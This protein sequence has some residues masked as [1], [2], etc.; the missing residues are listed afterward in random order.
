MGEGF[1]RNIIVKENE[2]SM[3]G[4]ALINPATAYAGDASKSGG[5]DLL[6]FMTLFDASDS[7]YG[8][9]ARRST[10]NGE[11]WRELGIIDKAYAINSNNDMMK[12]LNGDCFYDEEAGVM[13]YVSMELLWEGNELTS[14]FRKRRLYYRLSFD[15]GLSW[16]D[17]IY[18][19]RDGPGFDK[20]HMFPGITYGKNMLTGVFKIIK[21]RGEGPN[22]GKIVLGISVQVLGE[23]GDTFN[24]TQWGFFKSGCLL[25]TWCAEQGRYDWK[26]CEAYASASWEDSSRGVIEPAISEAENGQ[27][28]MIL[29]GSNMGQSAGSIGS[30]WI[31]RSDD[32]GTTWSRPERLRYDTGEI[33]YSS[34][35][36]PVVVKDRQQR[37]FYV[38]VI[39]ESNPVGNLPRYPLC[40]AEIDQATLRVKK[41]SVAVLDTIRREHEAQRLSGGKFPVDYTNHY[42]YLDSQHNRIIV[43]APYRQDISRFQSGL[44]RYDIWL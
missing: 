38:G 33:M 9:L 25:G 13:I 19:H 14:T 36:I 39:N 5:G 42:A 34:S 44:N 31:S 18:I 11:T 32:Q 28:L 24:P 3:E 16:S 29:R 20:D 27:L 6:Q 15:N 23:D 26:E 1:Y 37:I 12:I 35:N 30:K 22:K 43:L 2:W 7:G 41:E 8:T 40:I 21:I 10:D 17:P 4:F